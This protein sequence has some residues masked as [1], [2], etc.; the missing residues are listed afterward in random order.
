MKSWQKE[1]ES[2]SPIFRGAPFWAWNAAL[3]PEELRRQ[4]GIMQDMGMGGFF[5]HSRVGMATPYLGEKWFEC[6]NACIDEAEK[7]GM[8]A[9]LYDED[10]WPSGAAGSLVTRDPRYRQRYLECKRIEGDPAAEAGDIW[11]R[12]LHGADGTFIRYTRVSSPGEGTESDGALFRFRLCLCEP[13]SWYNGATYLD[14]LNPEA[15]KRFLEVTHEAYYAHCGKDFGKTVPGIFTDEPTFVHHGDWAAPWTDALPEKFRKKYGYD[16]LD[17]LP[18]LFFDCGKTVSQVRWHYRDMLT[19]LFV[20]AFAGQIGPWCGKHGIAMTGHV[21]MEDTLDSQTAA[22]GSAMRSYEHMQ[23]PGI[24]LLTEYWQIFNTAKQCSSAARQTGR[25]VRLSE[26]YGCT[27]WDFPFMGHKALGDWQY[28]LGINFRCQHL[29]WYSMEGEAKRDYPA[30]ISFQS[31]W[32]DKYH[33]VEDYFARLGSVL[34]GGKEIRDILMIHPVESAWSIRLSADNWN[35]GRKS[36]LLGQLDR[37]WVNLTDHLLSGNVDFDFGDEE[38]LSRLAKVEKDVFRVGQAEYKAVVIPRIL[39]I[40][41]STLKLLKEWAENGGSVV[42]IGEPPAFVDALPSKEAE[43]IYRSY[44]V[45]A[46]T[47]WIEEKLLL[48]AQRRLSVTDRSGA[49]IAP[50]LSRLAE[51]DGSY[52]L[53]LCNT[54]MTFSD[55]WESPMVRD[56]NLAFPEAEVRV[57]LPE[58]GGVYELDPA[59][60]RVYE[61]PFRRENGYYV[62]RTSFAPLQSRLFLF[63]A[64]RPEKISVRT[65]FHAECPKGALPGGDEWTYSLNDFNSLVLDHC[66]LKAGG[67]TELENAFFIQADDHLRKM[68]GAAPRGGQMVQPWLRDKTVPEKQLDIELTYEIDCV[69]IPAE[70]CLLALERP[71]LYSSILFNGTAL[72]RDPAGP[73]WWVDPVLKTLRMPKTLFRQGKNLLTLSGR[74]HEKLPGLESAFLLGHFGVYDGKIGELPGRLK[75]G[76]WV[77][78]GLQ[79]YSGDVTYERT[80]EADPASGEHW[81]LRFGAW[82][83]AALTVSVNGGDEQPIPWP[84]FEL[85]LTSGLVKGEN[86]IAIRVCG[87]R[88]NAFG[89]F[90]TGQKWM[91]WTGPAQFKEYRSSER[92]LVPSGLLEMPDLL[93]R[94]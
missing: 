47:P 22:V 61:V 72:S 15:V 18:E 66:T 11:F 87:S 92:Q 71:E 82:R 28:A 89:P 30:S 20:S 88:R 13:S 9:W 4:I 67:R 2:P 23:M 8:K 19:D 69:R 63:T 3:E 41:S 83:G 60:G 43:E 48:K 74:Y 32:H 44:F 65:A 10:R 7:R 79:E 42:Y 40:R 58:N 37:Q 59:N 85:D 12:V 34:T 45:F 78:Q 25:D 31:S 80:F 86:R 51:K 46:E 53:F 49:Q 38:M 50:V 36:E 84:P 64:E 94:K 55:P 93:I 14:T 54:S 24:D 62:F 1:F 91:A 29:A 17:R 73:G 21:L 76:D 35:P 77:K 81:F 75:T 70:D 68:L 6:I 26:T 39:T 56:R 33:V 57:L 52:N 5:M 90:F 27:G 16:I